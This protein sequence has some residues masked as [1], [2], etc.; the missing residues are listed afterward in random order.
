MLHPLEILY[1]P[2]SVS[3]AHHL[4]K[5][6]LVILLVMVIVLLV[7]VVSIVLSLVLNGVLVK[8]FPSMVCV[9]L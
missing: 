2:D 8:C 7:M 9:L 3:L 6:S 4:A 5:V 1:T